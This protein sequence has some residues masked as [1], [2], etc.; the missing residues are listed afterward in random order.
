MTW[1]RG[2]LAAA[3]AVLLGCGGHSPAV[4]PS[5]DPVRPPDSLHA[6]VQQPAEKGLAPAP[7]MPPAEAYARGLMPLNETGIDAF[8]KLHPTYDGRGVIIAVLD[9]G[10]D[11]GVAGL[12]TTSTGERKILDLRDFSGEGAIALA[13]ARLSGDTI[14]IAGQLLKGMGRVAGLAVAGTIYAGAVNER[15]MGEAP[16]ADLN[17]NGASTDL[18]PVVVARSSEGWFLLADTDGDGSFANQQPIRDYL[19]GH[20]TFGWSTGGRATPM[21]IA[22][23][24]AAGP[25]GVPSLDLFF[26]GDG[27]GSHVAGI[28]AG[29]NLYGV[30]GFDGVAPGA[31]LLGLKIARDALGGISVTGS[32]F[33]AMEYAIRFARARGL[34]LVMNMSYGVGNEVEGSARIDAIVDSVLAANPGVVLTISAGNDGPG[35]STLGFPGSA[36]RALTVGATYPSA[37]LP[38]PP[39][40]P[41]LAYFSSRGGELAKPDIVT[42]GF[43]YSTVPRWAIGDEQKEGTSMASPYAAGL[44]ATLASGLA[45]ERKPIQ[46]RMIKQALMVTAHPLAGQGYLDQGTGLPQVGAAWV[47]VRAGHSLPE[48][49][50]R[51]EGTGAGAAI[52]WH[53]FTGPGDTTQVFTLQSPGLEAAQTFTLRSDSPWLVAPSTVLVGSQPVALTLSYRPSAV[54]APGA[55]SAV[56][57]GWTS[58]TAAG[59]AFRLLNTVVVPQAGSDFSL[60]PVAVAATSQRRF[61]LAADSA[62]PFLVSVRS[63]AGGGQALLAFLQ[64]PGGQ[65]FRED[66]PQLISPGD[67][68]VRFQVDGR[69]VVTGLYELTAVGSP[70]GGGAVALGL[71]T[72]PLSLSAVSG[73]DGEHLRLENHGGTPIAGD[74]HLFVIGAE[75]SVLVVGHGGKEERVAFILPAWAVRASVDLTM[76]R[77]LWPRFTDFGM[78]IADSSGHRLQKEPLNYAFGRMN[79][80]RPPGSAAL[81]VQLIL[82]PGLADPAPDQAWTARL[83][84]R[85]YADSTAAVA[86]PPASFT[87]APGATADLV[88][89]VP[90]SSLSLGDA[91]YP[92]GLVGVPLGDEIWT[93][94]VPIPPPA[95]PL[96]R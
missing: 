63:P 35:L 55:Y 19:D 70:Y 88:V 4:R 13:P 67:S 26:D 49:L 85:L 38:E 9:G 14:R 30:A 45:Q 96:A 90:A 80:E 89:P 69:D 22:V 79:L 74:A 39:V 5:I 34:P 20:E 60:P 78:T 86:A 18:L 47:W 87:V 24:L 53:G 25:D 46:A 93:W 81:P 82:S 72:S 7:V 15:A 36:S 51:A 28:A 16:A 71:S 92:L 64:E 44:A 68:T 65:P 2:I 54:Q 56:V 94:E 83:S 1:H 3:T 48:V 61:F 40:R 59:P 57:T 58:D 17:G 52:R 6:P 23:N 27:H 66:G 62:R 76:D 41:F 50:A 29:H 73:R 42:P 75:R 91:F 12:F 95:K 31:Q 77:E 8:R 32:M 33:R 11:A 84:I 10:V 37:F 43:A 21:T